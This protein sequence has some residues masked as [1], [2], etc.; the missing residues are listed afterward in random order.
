MRPRNRKWFIFFPFIIIAAALF[1][2]W[3]VMLL[4]NAVLVPAT[5]VA[6][7]NYWQ[8]VGLLV[9]SRIL[10]SGFRGRP[11]SFRGGPPH[12]KE[13]WINMSEDEKIKFREEWKKRC[14]KK[15]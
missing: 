12:W 10:F 9:L 4:W 1:F 11:G 2:G 7:L 3:V 15:D 14:E 13:K 6:V 8:G 5:S